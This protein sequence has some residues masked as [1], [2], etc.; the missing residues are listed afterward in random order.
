MPLL[1]VLAI[2]QPI[3]LA[4]VALAVAVHAEPPPDPT[5]FL[6]APAA[7]LGT[8]GIAA[9]YRGMAIGT[10]SVVAP[11]AALGVVIPVG[12]GLA[13]GEDPTVAQLAG[14]VVAILGVVLSSRDTEGELAGG[15]LAAG[16]PWAI[17]AA[18][19]FGGYFVPMKAASE[20]DFLWATLVFRMTSV[21]L[22]LAA[23]AA[24]RPQ[25]RVGRGDLPALAAIGVLDTGA[26]VLF[27]AA[28]GLGLISVVSVLSSLYP[29]VTVALA[30][31]YLRERVRNVQR[32]GVALA[33]AGVVLISAG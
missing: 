13:R 1:L 16:V 5:V 14:F 11:I 3:G 32:V 30:W 21:P 12:F 9:F 17:V 25:L 19:G 2:A 7:V 26:T 33:L 6:A 29:V 4:A 18:V 15:R 31:I 27:A 10:I 23:L 22:V 20:D 24:A 28:S 8:V